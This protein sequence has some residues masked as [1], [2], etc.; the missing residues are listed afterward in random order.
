MFACCNDGS[1][2]VGVFAV[3]EAGGVFAGFVPFCS[4][5]VADAYVFVAPDFN[6]TATYVAFH[7]G[8]GGA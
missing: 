3:I 4:A 2:F 5:I 7:V 1:A 8:H 6:V